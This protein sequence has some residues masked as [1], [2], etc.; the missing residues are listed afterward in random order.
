MGDADVKLK[1]AQT[2]KT[3]EEIDGVRATVEKTRAE[4]KK[5]QHDAKAPI[6]TPIPDTGAPNL[7]DS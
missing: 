4:A 1:A 3:T 6:Q 7:R 5:M 2:A